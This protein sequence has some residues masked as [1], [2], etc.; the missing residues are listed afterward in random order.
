[1]PSRSTIGKKRRRQ[2]DPEDEDIHNTE[3]RRSCQPNAFFVEPDG[4]T[5]EQLKALSTRVAATLSREDQWFRV[6]DIVCP[7][8]QPRPVSPYHETTMCEA[9]LTYIRKYGPEVL[10]ASLR[11]GDQLP[12]GLDPSE[13]EPALSQALIRTLEQLAASTP[14]NEHRQDNDKGKLNELPLG[15]ESSQRIASNPHRPRTEDTESCFFKAHTTQPTESGE[16]PNFG[17]A[18]VGVEEGDQFW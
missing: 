14:V 5:P 18:S 11:Q 9:T 4:T 2:D 3:K 17:T 6:F 16:F 7:G 13:I 10:I 1:M 8:H 12:Q 15:A